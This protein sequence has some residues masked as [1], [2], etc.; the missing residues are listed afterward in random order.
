MIRQWTITPLVWE[1]IVLRGIKIVNSGHH[2]PLLSQ[3][4]SI[5]ILHLIAIADV[6]QR[7]MPADKRC[8]FQCPK[9]SILCQHNEV[10][11]SLCTILTMIADDYMHAFTPCCIIVYRE[12]QFHGLQTFLQ[13]YKIIM[14]NA[15]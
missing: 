11:L 9:L 14:N 7:M 2:I 12:F 10:L 6:R 5:S 8:R 4:L 13:K 1:D 3:H 15:L